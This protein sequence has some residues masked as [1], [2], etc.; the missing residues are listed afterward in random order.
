MSEDVG[1]S[2]MYW[3]LARTVNTQEPEGVSVAKGD[4]GGS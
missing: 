1:V 2:G 3:G 4:I